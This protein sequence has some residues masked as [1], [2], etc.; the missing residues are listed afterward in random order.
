MNELVFRHKLL[1][2]HHESKVNDKYDSYQIKNT[3]T[4]KI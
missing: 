1:F 3:L 4:W 2:L